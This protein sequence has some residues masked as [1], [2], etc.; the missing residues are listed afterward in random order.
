VDRAAV[1]FNSSSHSSWG[2][3]IVPT[4]TANTATISSDDSNS[5]SNSGGGGGGGSVQWHSYTC[6]WSHSCGVNSWFTNSQVSHAVSS[7]PYGPFKRTGAKKRNLR[8]SL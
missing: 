6:E 8:L 3:A 7:S 2:A 1:G 4:T 5:N